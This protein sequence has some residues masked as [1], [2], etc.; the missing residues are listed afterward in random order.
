M[1]SNRHRKKSAP[2]VVLSLQIVGFAS[3]VSP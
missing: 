3:V 2:I 1:R